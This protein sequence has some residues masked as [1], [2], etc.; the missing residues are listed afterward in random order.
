M[1]KSNLKLGEIL[2]QEGLITTDQLQEALELQ[3]KDKCR[4]G[5]ALVKIKVVT[6]REIALALSKQ[7]GVLYASRERGLL[8]PSLFQDLEKLVPEDFSRL[9]KVLPLSRHLNSLTVACVDPFD[10][11]MMDNLTKMTGCDINPVVTTPKEIADATDE[12]YG[13]RDLLKEAIDSSYQLTQDDKAVK[14]KEAGDKRDLEKLIA[15]AGEAPVIKLV[16]LVLM[17]AIE[18]RASDIHVEKFE[19]RVSIRYRVDGVLFEISP[20]AKGLYTAIVSRIKLL[21]GMDI[22]EHRL[23]QDGGFS[24]QAGTRHLDLRVSC[25]PTI[26]G[27][28]IVIRLLDKSGLPSGLGVLGFEKDELELLESEVVK[29]QGMIYTTGP[30]GSG[31]TTT[32][33][34]ILNTIKSPEKN[35]LTVED[36]VEYKLDGVNQVQ[37]KPAIELTFASA[38]R[39]FLRQDPDIILVGEC[40]DLETVEICVRAALTGHLVFSTLHTNDAAGAIVRLTDMG[41]E[42]FLIEA[43]LNLII[44]Q[45]LARK[46]CP[47]CKEE[48]PG[49]IDVPHYG[50]ITT[51][52]FKAKGCEEC[53]QVGYKGRVGLYEILKVS[54]K[55]RELIH[56]RASTDAVREAAQKE[57]MNTLFQAGVEKV[58]KGLTTLEEVLSV[59]TVEEG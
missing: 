30:T 12:F 52:T 47:K 27:E 46:L 53:H 21:S 44:A 57:G 56:N 7:L 28:K 40:R 58:K 41:A 32:L 17:Q 39:A 11:L 3:K 8:R 4:L 51:P 55:I 33:Y 13:K 45:R 31:K 25:I 43:C 54:H 37:I 1:I 19:T 5:E 29:P 34:A 10:L 49:P 35:I 24:I 50:K 26:H 15:E 2:Q 42:P 38:L 36:P 16:D 6:E 23:P 59:V 14:E 48:V 20:P 18:N 22:A 9:Y